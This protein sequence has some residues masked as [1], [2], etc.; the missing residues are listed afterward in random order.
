MPAI[1]EPPSFSP[2]LDSN[3]A[4]PAPQSSSNDVE[5]QVQHGHG[6]LDHLPGP[7]PHSP[8]ICA[9]LFVLSSVLLLHI[10]VV[11]VRSCSSLRSSRHAR[12]SKDSLASREFAGPASASELR[13]AHHATTT[14]WP[15]LRWTMDKSRGVSTRET[16]TSGPPQVGSDCER[17][18]YHS[19]G[20]G[21]DEKSERSP[22]E[23]KEEDTASAPPGNPGNTGYCSSQ[24]SAMLD[25][26]ARHSGL[27]LM[28][29]RP[30]PPPLT[31]PTLSQALFAAPYEDYR[32]RPATYTV[33][34]PPKDGLHG[35]SKLMTTSPAYSPAAAAAFFS[36][37]NPDYASAVS[38]EVLAATSSSSRPAGNAS[39]SSSP[40]LPRRKSYSKMLPLSGGS[41]QT[42]TRTG[43]GHRTG[44]ASTAHSSAAPLP[45]PPPRRGPTSS[46]SPVTK[47]AGGPA[48]A[49]PGSAFGFMPPASDPFVPSSYPPMSPLLPPPP[50][51]S[52]TMGH[53]DPAAIP[54]YEQLVEIGP[55]GTTRPAAMVGVQGEIL[56]VVDDQGTGWKRHTR[57]YGGGVCLACVAAGQSNHGGFYGATVRPEEKL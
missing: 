4:G 54:Y 15:S 5:V 43:G 50:P 45:I 49:T 19:D 26:Q 56:S 28:A 33:A 14:I 23:G 46:S 48:S 10:I 44:G 37:P 34:V 40:I 32:R 3:V 52:A 47:V 8:H 29:R 36:Q 18:P 7:W 53:G 17:Q 39:G 2:P 24:L 31:P 22:K 9:A 12:R 35:P 30:P 11:Q 16:S 57:V 27:N 1:N 20:D 6:H 21:N 13:G 38:D 25:Q 55:D 42:G 41:A 51:T